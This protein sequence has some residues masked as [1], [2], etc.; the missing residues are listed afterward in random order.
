[1]SNRLH[2]QETGALEPAMAEGLLE[3]IVCPLCEADF[4]ADDFNSTLRCAHGHAFPRI[5]GVPKLLPEDHGKDAASIARSFGHQWKQFDYTRDRTWGFDADQRLRTFLNESGRPRAWFKGRHVLDAGCGNGVLS[6]MIST[7][8]CTVLATDVSPSVFAAAE[9]LGDDV[10]FVQSDLAQPVFRRGVF[11]FVYCS[12]VL[13][14]TANTRRALEQV[15]RAVAPSGAIYVWL[16]W[17]V[18][19]VKSRVKAVIRKA[20]RPLPDPVKRAVAMPFALQGW[21]RDRSLS[22]QEHFLIQHDFFTPRYR[23]EHRPEDV[24]AWFRELGFEKI[25][26]QTTSKDGFGVLAEVR[27]APSA[28]EGS[29][30][31]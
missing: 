15:A 13:H 9:R 24:H 4:E 18:P 23:W 11:D 20:I 31:T 16:Y 6:S 22:L 12:G 1:M 19:G 21:L 29:S 28:A 3:L 25:V 10:H 8:G 7:L 2:A 27:R 30:F 17:R 5:A 26:T 14:H